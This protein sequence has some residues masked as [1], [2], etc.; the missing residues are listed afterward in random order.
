MPC[1][2]IHAINSNNIS[3]ELSE[4]SQ[5]QSNDIDLCT[6]FCFCQCCQTISIPSFYDVKLANLVDF[7]LDYKYNES[8]YLSP[9]LEQHAHVS[10]FGM[11]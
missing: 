6:P 11:I 8:A 3:L 2:D 9:V 10:S 5:N 4:Q 1:D 7:T